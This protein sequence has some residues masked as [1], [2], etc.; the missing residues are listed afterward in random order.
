[1]LSL[2]ENKAGE[3]SDFPLQSWRK[4]SPDFSH[5]KNMKKKLTGGFQPTGIGLGEN[6]IAGLKNAAVKII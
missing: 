6:N 1:M 5:C 4:N 3:K 2:P